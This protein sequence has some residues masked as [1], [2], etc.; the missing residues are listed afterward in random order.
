[1]P[2]PENSQNGDTPIG[3]FYDWLRRSGAQVSHLAPDY[4]YDVPQISWLQIGCVLMR[5]PIRN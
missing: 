2:H 4:I 1:M 3:V 5:R